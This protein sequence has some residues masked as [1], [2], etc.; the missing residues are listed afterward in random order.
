MLKSTINI[1]FEGNKKSEILFAKVRILGRFLEDEHP[2][3]CQI[4][5]KNA[6]YLKVVV[7]VK[8]PYFCIPAET[9]LIIKY[10]I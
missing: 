1:D 2:R 8:I 10:G 6:L 3:V 5:P 7:I 4:P 9:A